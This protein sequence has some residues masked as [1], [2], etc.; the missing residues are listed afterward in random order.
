MWDEDRLNIFDYRRSMLEKCDF[1]ALSADLSDDVSDENLSFF[2][3]RS[4]RNRKL[5][6]NEQPILSDPIWWS[7]DVLMTQPRTT[8]ALNCQTL[9][10]DLTSPRCELQ[11]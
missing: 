2:E 4:V 10:N 1:A 6:L 9:N 8:L 5:L 7:S 11:N 3:D